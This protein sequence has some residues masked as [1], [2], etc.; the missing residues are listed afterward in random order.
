MEGTFPKLITCITGGVSA[1]STYVYR[2]ISMDVV[3]GCSSFVQSRGDNIVFKLN[4]AIYDSSYFSQMI[5]QWH[6]PD[7]SI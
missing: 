7:W 2:I 1:M 6:I 3:V 5:E 4:F